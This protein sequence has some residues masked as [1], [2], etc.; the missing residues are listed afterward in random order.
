VQLVRWR[1]A[2]PA[3]SVVGLLY[4]SVA[5][6][7]QGQHG[8]EMER[9]RPFVGDWAYSQV[10][11]TSALFPKG[12]HNAGHW[13]AQWGPRGLSLVLTFQVEGTVDSGA[14]LEIMTWD[15]KAQVYRDHAIWYDAPGQWEFTGRFEGAV[16]VYRGEFDFQGRH[17]KLR[18][19][20]RAVADS[21]FTITEY[22]SI[23]G[24]PEQRILQGKAEPH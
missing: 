24:G 16:L 3:L 4:A 11:D 21:G 2:R 14:G 22:A 15:P 20:T 8:A 17:V 5:D 7:L 13:T 19:E 6:F 18:Y 10:F 9:L 12:G 23:D 1:A